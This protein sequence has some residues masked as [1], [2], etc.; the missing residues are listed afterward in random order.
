MNYEKQKITH[1]DLFSGIG[2]FALA[3]ER[4]WGKE[5]IEHIFCD[6]E[7]FAQE[8]LKKHWPES[9]IYG[10]IRT[11]AKETFTFKEMQLPSKTISGKRTHS[12]SFNKLSDSGVAKRVK[13]INYESFTTNTNWTGSGAPTSDTLKDWQ[14]GGE[15]RKHSQSQFGRP[16][17]L[18]GG[19]PCQPFSQAGRR[20]GE[21]DDRFLWPEML[22]I[23]REFSPLWVIAENVRGLL[24]QGGGVVFERVCTDLEAAGYEVQPIIIP[25]VAVGAPHRRDRVW[26]VAHRNDTRSGTPER[27]TFSYRTESSE[28]WKDALTRLDGQGGNDTNPERTQLEGG[29][30]S[31]T[32]RTKSS[33]HSADDSD[34]QNPI[35]KRGSGRVESSGQI[36]G[37][38]STEA[39]DARPSWETHWLEVATRLC[40]VDDGLPRRM[41]RNPR[42]KALGNAIVPQV[43]EEIMRAML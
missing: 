6:N 12:S 19:F 25:A 23:I 1:I 13:Q 18:T 32:S 43:A 2:G 33:E 8:V 36:L 42:L 31:E 7:P 22:R 40:R 24:T 4:V 17:I 41:D 11:L 16:F 29:I 20:R 35:S 14:E 26:F 15:E 37:R 27:Q 3:A 30:K 21:E 9:K 5:N 39:Q 28:E 10:D 34:A 38:E